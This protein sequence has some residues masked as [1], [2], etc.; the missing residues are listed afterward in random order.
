MMD[1]VVSINVP[2]RWADF[3]DFVGID[4]TVQMELGYL[5]TGESL[6]GNVAQYCFTHDEGHHDDIQRSF[7]WQYDRFFIQQKK[8]LKRTLKQASQ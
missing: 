8:T 7:E 1:L 5:M 3:F 6:D 2:M 4:L